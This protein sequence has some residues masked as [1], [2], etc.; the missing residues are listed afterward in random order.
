MQQHSI[1]NLKDKAR[2]TSRYAR[3]CLKIYFFLNDDAIIL[4]IVILPGQAFIHT[5]PIYQS[6]HIAL[7]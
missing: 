1:P 3:E 5:L 2:G 6:L 4:V 7:L